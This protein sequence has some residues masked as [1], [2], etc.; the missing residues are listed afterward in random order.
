MVAATAAVSESALVYVARFKN[1]AISLIMLAIEAALAAF[2]IIGMRQLGWSIAWQAT[3]PALALALSLGMSAIAKATLLQRL[4][5]A[6]IIGWRWPIVWATAA[7]VVVGEVAILG[8]E[9]AELIF[10]IPAI[11][12]A[13]GAIIWVKGFGPDDR[14][15]FRMRKGEVEQLANPEIGRAHV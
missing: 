8:P 13:F 1:M 6:P 5:G 11:L 12:A 14:E 15:L 4:L 9:W 10:G 7:A 2:L 3:G